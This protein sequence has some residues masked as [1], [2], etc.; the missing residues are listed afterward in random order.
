MLYQDLGEDG[1]IK[2][3]HSHLGDPLGQSGSMLGPQFDQSAIQEVFNDHDAEIL[4]VHPDLAARAAG[5]RRTKVDAVP[6][7]SAA[8]Q[9]EYEP[10]RTPTVAGA[11]RMAFD[12]A[13]AAAPAPA[14][15][16]GFNAV[17]VTVPVYWQVCPL[18][19]LI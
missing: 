3:V 6:A 8:E 1:P 7:A 13:P 17:V 15:T 14:G 19:R 12:A 4:I 11:S 16:Q 9:L 18:Y 5:W 2:L 10:T